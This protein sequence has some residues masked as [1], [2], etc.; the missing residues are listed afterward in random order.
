[1]TV[2][3]ES[4][5]G[6]PP[7]DA[8]IVDEGL[9]A[10][11]RESAP[12]DAVLHVTCLA[13]DADGRVVGGAVG[14]TWGECAELMQLWV[15]PAHRQQGIGAS[16]VRRF[17]DRAAARGCRTCY[18]TTFSFQA[19]ALYRALGYAPASEIRGFP[20]GIVKYLMVR[21]LQGPSGRGEIP[22]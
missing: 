1:M 16:L 18:L 14:R 7:A 3:Y 17:E 4:L 9:E 5:D 12:L 19:P 11:N 15:S 22:R 13:R 8:A 20:R 2:I 6:P 10:D 21:T